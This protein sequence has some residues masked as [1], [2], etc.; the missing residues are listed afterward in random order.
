MVTSDKTKR[1][2]DQAIN[3]NSILLEV[4]NIGLFSIKPGMTHQIKKASYDG[5]P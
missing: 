1:L 5:D 3:H 4:A 2:R